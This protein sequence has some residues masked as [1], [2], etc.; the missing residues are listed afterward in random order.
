MKKKNPLV[1]SLPG[2]LG[3]MSQKQ[4]D[5]ESDQYDV[6]F[7]ATR[8]KRITNSKPHPKKPGRPQTD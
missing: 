6:L 3:R 2:K 8:A 4:L 7:S 1:L 5:A